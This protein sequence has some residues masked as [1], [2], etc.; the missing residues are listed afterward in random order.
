MSVAVAPPPIERP[1]STPSHFWLHAFSRPAERQWSSLLFLGLLCGLLFFYGLCAGELWRTESLRAIV[2]AEFLRSGNWVVPTLYGNPLLTKPP[3][4]YAAI[5]LVSWPLG[6]VSE[7][8]ARLPSALAATVTVLLAYWY[9][10]RQLGR[11]GGLVAATVLPMSLLW[12]DK[13]TAAEI[14]MLQ[15]AWVTASL[16]FFLRAL[17]AEETRRQGDTETRRER[18][19]RAPCLHVSLSPC[20]PFWW[21]ASLLCV[22]GGFLTKWTAPA[23][24]YGTVVPLL[25]WRGRLRLL[26]GRHHLVSAALGAAVCLAWVAAAVAQVG[27]DDFYATVS[28]EAATRLLPNRHHRPYPWGEVLLHPL[29]V[30]AAALPWSVLIVVTLRPGFARLWDER[31]LRLLQALHCWVWPNLLF[32][33]AIP[34]K[35]VRH[36][37]P[38]LPG[39]AGLAALVWVAWLTGRLRW[40][41]TRLTP[42]RLL[43]AAVVLWLGVK[44]VFVH[45]VVPLREEGREPRAKGEL[46]SRLVPPGETLYL[47]RLKDEG[48]M[49]YYGRPVRRLPGPG[50]LP[51]PARRLFCILDESEW[52]KWQAFATAGEAVLGYGWQAGAGGGGYGWGEA[53]LH[54][55]D[56]QGDPIVLVKVA[57]P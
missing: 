14:D 40:P 22:A 35:P 24:F 45:A 27:W 15:V 13:A 32:W 6:G 46:L 20:L 51:S 49:F 8:T 26:W 57:R 5:A 30:L 43:V 50:Q 55:R 2:A 17:E 48:I 4:A 52:H 25:W 7:W 42:G 41:L 1:D 12:L 31:G 10:G 19:T 9:F 37:F 11:L 21:L 33:S 36:S 39:V 56:E 29:K 18:Q 23:F 28:Q 34:A 47:F 16:L 38:V 3:G 44:V 53:I 54:L